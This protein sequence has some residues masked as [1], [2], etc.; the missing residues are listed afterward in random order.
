MQNQNSAQP[1]HVD[2]LAPSKLIRGQ[3][4]QTGAP[5]NGLTQSKSVISQKVDLF[6][7]AGKLKMLSKPAA[8]KLGLQAQPT[9][10]SSA[11]Q[12]QFHSRKSSVK[13][14]KRR[15]SNEI[16]DEPLPTSPSQPPPSQAAQFS[17]NNT[18]KQQLRFFSAEARKEDDLAAA[19]SALTQES[20][21]KPQKNSKRNQRILPS[22]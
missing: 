18:L 11:S 16:P 20:A 3:A 6:S 1:V 14:T 5:V 15:T 10:A 12:R 9:I 21:S 2:S 4:L 22:L 7:I 19:M 17:R 13:F 8:S